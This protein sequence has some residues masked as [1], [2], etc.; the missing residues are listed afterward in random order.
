LLHLR[1]GILHGPEHVDVVWIVHVVHDNA[2]V[3]F[4]DAF[5][6]DKV[7]DLIHV[8]AHLLGFLEELLSLR[9]IVLRHKLLSLC[10]GSHRELL[11]ELPSLLISSWVWVD[12]VLSHVVEE[13]TWHF[14]EGLLRKQV[15]VVLELIEGD[16]LNDISC[17]VL[18]VGRGVEGLVISIERVHTAEVSIANSDDN[19]G[20]RVLRASDNLVDGLVHVVDDTIGEDDKDVELLLLLS[21]WLR[22]SVLIRLS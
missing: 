17:H 19:D 15:W 16:K 21:D 14:H 8:T 7:G 9:V 5:L 18:P 13:L 20:K 1:H 11:L 12:V 4:T 3:V 6:V 2:E 22:L 10:V